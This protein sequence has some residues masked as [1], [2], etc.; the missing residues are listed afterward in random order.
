MR[1]GRTERSISHGTKREVERRGEITLVTRARTKLAGLML[2]ASLLGVCFALGQDSPRPRPVAPP[3]VRP[4]LPRRPRRGGR[5]PSREA[6]SPHPNCS[7]PPAG[8]AGARRSR[9]ADHIEN[10]VRRVRPGLLPARPSVIRGRRRR[11]AR[12]RRGRRRRLTPPPSGAAGAAAERAADLSSATRSATSASE[13]GLASR[14]RSPSRFAEAADRCRRPLIRPRCRRRPLRAQKIGPGDAVVA[15][16][17]QN[18]RSDADPGDAIRPIHPVT[19][20]PKTN[21]PSRFVVPRPG[22]KRPSEES[23]AGPAV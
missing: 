3:E 12:R 5:P 4:S 11:I 21:V 19:P 7:E 9:Q 15:A 16:K 6:A 8:L 17:G 14:E 2:G 18:L 22:S 13:S 1:R 20:P 10:P 23:H